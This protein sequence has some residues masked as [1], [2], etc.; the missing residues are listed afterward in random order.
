MNSKRRFHSVCLYNFGTD[1]IEK[2]TVK[3]KENI[4]LSRPIFRLAPPLKKRCPQISVALEART[5]EKLNMVSVLTAA[6]KVN[7]KLQS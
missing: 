4:S 2:Y 7:V 1:S 6:R 5:K 3:L